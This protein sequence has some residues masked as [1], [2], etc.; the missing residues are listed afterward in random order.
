MLRQRGV[1]GHDDGSTPTTRT[2]IE[3]EL[4]RSEFG[5]VSH[6]VGSDWAEV[7][8]DVNELV[9]YERRSLKRYRERRRHGDDEDDVPF[10]T[11]TPRVSKSR[12]KKKKTQT[13]GEDS[14][15]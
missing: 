12:K 10:P 8:D 15:P 1:D 2:E 5:V 9:P 13:D 11:P 4:K 14:S 6:V 3:V 7:R